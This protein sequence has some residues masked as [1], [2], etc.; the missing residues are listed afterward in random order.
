MANARLLQAVC[1]VALLAAAP[2]F[3]QQTTTQPGDTGAGNPVAPTPPRPR[4][5]SNMAPAE[6]MDSTS[7]GSSSAAAGSHSTHHA[8]MMGHSG[9]GMHARTDSSQNSA[10]D[11][12]NDQ[13]FQAAQR[14]QSFSSS[15][16][17][18]SGS[19]MPAGSGSMGGMSGGSSSPASAASG[20][21]GGTGSGSGSG[22]K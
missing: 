8:A 17:G 3:A 16:T 18:T 19:M 4:A 6:K 14:G 13:S 10:V 15:D 1:T 5:Q 11:Q 2:A 20:S 12:L 9:G 22:A 7:G 21:G